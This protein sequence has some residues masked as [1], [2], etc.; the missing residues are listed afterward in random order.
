MPLHDFALTDARPTSLVSYNPSA[1]I[2]SV[3]YLA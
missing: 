2:A 1:P 3:I